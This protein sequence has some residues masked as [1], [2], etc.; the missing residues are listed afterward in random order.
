MTFDDGILTIYSVE[1]IGE[2]GMMPVTGLVKKDQYY[3]GFDTLGINRFYTALQAK[4][5]IECV[6]NIPGWGNITALD[7]CELENGM[8]YRIAMRQPSWNEDGLKITKLSLERI[9]EKYDI[10]IE[11]DP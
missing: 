11:S 5:Q 10:K 7:I 2:P 4:Q 8:Q 6:V 9:D 3:Y 1:N